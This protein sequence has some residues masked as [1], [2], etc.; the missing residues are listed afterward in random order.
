VQ[1]EIV[2]DY[3]SAGNDDAFAPAQAAYG[4]YLGNVNPAPYREGVNYYATQYGDAAFFV[5]DTRAYRSPNEAEDDEHKTMLG[6]S[7]KEDLFKW[8]AEVNQTVTW[9]F[10]VS[11]VPLH[12][13]YSHG[14]D[15][16]AGFLNERDQVMDVLETVD[17]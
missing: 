4:D 14:D 17:K 8:A 6:Q 12:S 11:S 10:V 7:Q 9:K 16:W 1:H 3:D 13:L 5:M 15:T 2:N